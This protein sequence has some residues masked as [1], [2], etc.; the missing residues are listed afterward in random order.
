[1]SR[2]VSKLSI[3]VLLVEDDK[4]LN[5][6]LTEILELHGFRVKGV[7]NGRDF[8]RESVLADYHVVVVDIG[9]PDQSGLVLIEYVR[10][11]LNSSVLA[12]SANDRQESRV[13]SYRAGADI[14]MP[15]P[16]NADEL[17]AAIIGLGLRAQQRL[18]G[19]RDAAE[20]PEHKDCWM[21]DP[22]RRQLVSPEAIKIELNLNETKSLELLMAASGETVERASMIETIYGRVDDSSQRALDTLMRRLRQKIASSTNGANPILTAYGVGHSFAEAH[23]IYS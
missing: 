19:D 14:F 20:V 2:D 11:N 8:Y 17:G 10:K 18:Y 23:L 12:I 5:S 16:L 6:A 22:L 4:D 21:L 3:Q 15:K 7:Q 9:L 13:D 1:M